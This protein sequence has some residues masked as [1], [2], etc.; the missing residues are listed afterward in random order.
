VAKYLLKATENSATRNF[1]QRHIFTFQVNKIK[2]TPTFG[3][4][5]EE[6]LNVSKEV[7]HDDAWN[8]VGVAELYLNQW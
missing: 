8:G 5:T 4:K 6:Y 2:Y 7:S 3:D 1:T